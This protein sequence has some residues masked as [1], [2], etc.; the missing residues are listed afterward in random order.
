MGLIGGRWIY[1]MSSS[2]CG[3]KSIR[4]QPMPCKQR[5]EKC[6]KVDCFEY[7]W[8]DRSVQLGTEPIVFGT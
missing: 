2:A 5:L 6:G 3:M 1:G 4:F 8:I 7:L